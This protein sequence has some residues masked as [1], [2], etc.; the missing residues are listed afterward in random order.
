MTTTSSSLPPSSP[1][2]SAA[3]A[4]ERASEAAPPFVTPT[5]LAIIVLSG[6]LPFAVFLSANATVLV[7]TGIVFA[8]AAVWSVLWMAV[9][10]GVRLLTRRRDPLPVAAAFVAF[11]LSFWNF[12][13]WL[14]HEAGSQAR[15]VLVLV[16]WTAVTGA[17]MVLLYRI[18]RSPRVGTFLLIF[19]GVWTFAALAGFPLTRAQI[20]GGTPL[21]LAEPVT[22][23]FR[24]TPNVYWFL[25][26][27][28][29]RS[30]QFQAITGEDNSWLADDLTDR[31]FSVSGTTNSAYLHTQLSV[32]STLAMDYPFVPGG[33]Y[34]GDFVTTNPVIMGDNPVVETFEANGY[35][36]V[37]AP[38]GSVEWVACPPEAVGDRVCVPPIGDSTIL[39][40][41]NLTLARETPVGSFPIQQNYNDLG[42][43]MAGVRA[44]DTG[45][46]PLFVYAHILG[47]HFPHRYRADCSLRDPFVEG[48]ELSGEERLSMYATDVQCFDRAFVDTVDDILADDPDAV[49]IMQ[50]DHGTRFSFTW[51]MTFE[52][53]KPANF[54]ERF[55][56][57][58][59]IRLPE[60]C[61]G[62]SIE[63]QPLVNTFR[64][65]FAC[66][67][68]EEPD[69]LAQRTFFSAF[70][71]ISTLTEV[72]REELEAP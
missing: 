42:S 56:A 26:D 1:A 47:P 43:V 70:H 15:H 50:S 8:D 27:E 48:Y 62:D 11:S 51:D 63:G 5:V 37:Y 34:R 14:P 45:D 66:L 16:V 65:V 13:R 4:P 7:H 58:N 38:D 44:L 12:G 57:V 69:L 46:Q 3:D 31:G 39:G 59:A 28:H 30:D 40:G 60:A 35:R 68:G 72:P 2:R 67:T 25:F 55:G 21:T 33:D 6:V 71:K 54:R 10:L 20:D 18:A 24:S 49:I 9:F 19:L 23:P 17:A 53:W 64:L 52:Q 29:S 32:A 41:T 61:R 36:Y 22:T